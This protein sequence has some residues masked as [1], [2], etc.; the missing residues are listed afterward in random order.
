MEIWGIV[1]IISIVVL[2]IGVV[3]YFLNSWAGKKTAEQNE[4]VAQHKQTVSMYIIDKKKDKITNANMPKAMVDQ[5]PRMAK[6]MKMPLVKAKIGPTIMTMM[7]EAETFKVLPVKKTVTVEVAG[8]YIV[9][10]KGMKTK[11]EMAE[12]RKSRRKDGDKEVP[13]KWHEKLRARFGR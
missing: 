7:C 10:M 8:A 4:M 1:L 6:M 9:S 13:Q 2:I 5:V 3:I 12:Q 11:M